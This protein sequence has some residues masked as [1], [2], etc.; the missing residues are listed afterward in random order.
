MT[1]RNSDDQ[2]R[3][4]QAAVRCHMPAL[5]GVR[6]I[7]ILMVLCYHVIW[8]DAPANGVGAKLFMAASG[9]GW[10]GVKLFFVLSGFLITGILLDSRGQPHA[11]RNFIMRR[12]LRIFP[13]YYTVL[14][15]AFAVMPL[16][17][18]LPPWLAAEQHDQLWLWTYLSNWCAPWSCGGKAFTHF[19][20]L[21]V[22]EQFYVLWPL[23][24]LRLRP[25]QL[26]VACGILILIALGSRFLLPLMLAPPNVGARAAYFFTFAQ[27]DALALGALAAI[28]LRDRAWTA[29]LL[30]AL[31]WLTAACGVAVTVLVLEAR[32]LRAEQRSVEL[33]GHSVVN[34]LF[35]CLIVRAAVGRPM[36]WSSAV[37]LRSKWLQTLGKYS[38]AIYVFHLPVSHALEG[39]MPQARNEGSLSMIVSLTTEAG[40]VLLISLAAALVSWRL[41]EQPALRL[42]RYFPSGSGGTL[43][44]A[45]ALAVSGV[46][47]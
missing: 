12:S 35:A 45:P 9:A 41:V 8:T 40:A 2:V 25:R 37:G 30:R 31:P 3:A 26:A 16:L 34:A 32:G 20:S 13:L 46:R 38:Y 19:W 33:W 42:K 36:P 28:A 43:P 10:T 23:L 1:A 15:F 39:L 27:W 24:A 22:E 6:G 29:W 7:A 21:A 47:D 14:F 5:D 4:A 44:P 18:H 11:W 17:G